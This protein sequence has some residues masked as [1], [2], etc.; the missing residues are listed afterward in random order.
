M[1]RR[2]LAL[3]LLKECWCKNCW[4]AREMVVADHNQR[5]VIPRTS[6]VRDAPSVFNSQRYA[7]DAETQFPDEFSDEI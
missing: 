4:P 6:H 1:Y 2:E 5:Q 3:E 7:H